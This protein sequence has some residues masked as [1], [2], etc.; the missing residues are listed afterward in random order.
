MAL[1]ALLA[2]LGA[3]LHSSAQ[4]LPAEAIAATV[5]GPTP[6][7]GVDVVLL[8]DVE[9]R[10]R[11]ELALAGSPDVRR[12]PPELEV[13]T[14]EQIVGEL[15]VAREA[16]RLGTA[17]PSEADRRREHDRLVT[18][19]GGPDGVQAFLR[20]FDATMAELDAIAE[21]RARVSAFFRANLEGTGEIS[22]A[23]VEARYL[24]GDHPFGDRL[25]EEVREPLRAWMASEAVRSDVARWIEV[26]RARTVVRIFL[27]ELE[28]GPASD[29]AAATP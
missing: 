1:G 25:L 17:E 16:T 26:L 20:R 10:A 6:A 19:L 24:A 29:E 22:D 13:A 12:V 7:A 18:T 23:Q 9:L 15:L 3:P 5:G 8:S 4:R 21:R 28:R 27:P 2:L 14:L 11:I